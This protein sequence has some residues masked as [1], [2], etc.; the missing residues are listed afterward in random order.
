MIAEKANFF[1]YRANVTAGA[2]L[3]P[4]SR[5]I[6]DL[7][8]LGASQEQWKNAIQDE[9]ILHLCTSSLSEYPHELRLIKIAGNRV[10]TRVFSLDTLQKCAERIDK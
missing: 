8:L 2:L 6:A 1:G 10:H 3:V 5:K 4:E 7:L 9:N